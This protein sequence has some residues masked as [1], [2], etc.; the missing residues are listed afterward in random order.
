M[1]NLFMIRE[2]VRELFL[3]AENRFF[4]FLTERPAALRELLNILVSAMR[5][6][7]PP[8]RNLPLTAFPIPRLPTPLHWTKITAL[9]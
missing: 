8:M 4:M 1:D 5:P 3:P 2:K 7:M 9:P 6:A